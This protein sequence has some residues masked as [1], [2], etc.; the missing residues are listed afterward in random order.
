MMRRTMTKRTVTL[1]KRTKR[2]TTK[3]MARRLRMRMVMV[4]FQKNPLIMMTMRQLTMKI[5]DGNRM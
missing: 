5:P 4:I 2:T 1:M 3:T